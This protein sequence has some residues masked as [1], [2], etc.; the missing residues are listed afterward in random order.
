[1][2]AARQIARSCAAGGVLLLALAAPL[3]SEDL[4]S[5]E[6]SEPKLLR[7]AL[8]QIMPDSGDEGANLL[9]AEAWCRRAAAAGADIALLPEMYQIGYQG[10]DEEDPEA[11]QVWR[12][13]AIP[14]DHPWLG[15]LRDLAVELEM[16]IGA[17]YLARQEGAPGN[18][19]TLFDRRGRVV[20]TY[21]KVNLCDFTF[22]AACE[23]GDAFHVCTLDTGRGPVEV[24]AMICYDRVFPNSMADLAGQGAELIL[25]PMADRAQDADAY[26]LRAY[27]AD[28]RVTICAV[29]YPEPMMGGASAVYGPLGETLAVADGSEALLIADIDLEAQR[30]MRAERPR[31][32]GDPSR[33]CAQR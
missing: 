12:D 20:L 16:A 7:V 14:A 33:Y 2:C 25:I 5:D 10:Y 3:S 18:A 27:A 31:G 4:A 8:L 32:A 1:M 26:E 15:R 11:A 21:H 22:E 30:S 29:N 9:R 17:T 19:F 23:P 28:H 13:K 6:A 24:G